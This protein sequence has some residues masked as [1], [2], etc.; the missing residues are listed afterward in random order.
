M[1]RIIIIEDDENIQ[2]ELKQSLENALYEVYAIQSFHQVA[3]Q[4]IQLKPD[5]VLLD[6]N[7]PTQDGLSICSEVR[8]TSDV[9][10]IFVTSNTT[11]MDEL[12]CIT[13]GGDDFIT[14]PYQVPILLARIAAVLKRTVKNDVAEEVRLHCG[15]IQLDLS[16]SRI[17]R[18]GRNA[19]LTKN[20]MKILYYL[21][22]KPGVIV[23]REELVDYLWDNQIFIDDNTLSVNITRIRGKLEQIGVTDFIKTKRGLGYI[24]S[25]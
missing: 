17:S 9:P 21:F 22:K 20:E 6:M 11:S 23:S 19:E 15:D 24:I 2:Q 12:N 16:T 13:R 5:L 8:R 1:Y 14:K 4:I 3:S 18:N 10:I 7:L 25:N